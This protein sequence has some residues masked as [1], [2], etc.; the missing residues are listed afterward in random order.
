MID[1]TSLFIIAGVLFGL[2]AGDAVMYGD[3]LRVQIAVA[4]NVSNAGF[5]EASAESVFMAEA[6]R[7]VRGD[8]V[9]PAPTLRVN[10]DPSV[11]TALAK[12]LN[13]DSVVAALQNQ[14][15]IDH[16]LVSGAVLAEPTSTKATAIQPVRPLTSGPKLDM[17][18]VV[19]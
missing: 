8:S 11:I 13:L 17:V 3:T 2:L 6:A 15:G 7:L 12:P 9:I 19:V 16:L 18:M 4:Q 5:T 10:A 14:L 1:F